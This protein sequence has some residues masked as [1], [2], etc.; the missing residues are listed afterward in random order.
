MIHSSYIF[1][2]IILA[3]ATGI[4]LVGIF[5]SVIHQQQPRMIEPK[6][7]G[8]MQQP[9]TPVAMILPPPVNY[10]NGTAA[11]ELPN[12][13]TLESHSRP[14]PDDPSVI[15]NEII[16]INRNQTTLP[17]GPPP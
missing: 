17:L 6:N 5:W 8:Y 2:I 3:V 7:N 11:V 9:P 13:S 10:P 4:I 12:G 15:C 14:C 16:I 1:L